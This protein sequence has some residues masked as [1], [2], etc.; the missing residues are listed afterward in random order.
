[1]PSTAELVQGLYEI[2]AELEALYPGRPFT[3]DGHLV[4]SIGET[5]VAERY[6]LKLM[7][8]ST[9][10]YDAI[11][12]IGRKVEIKCTQGKSVAFRH[13]PEW[14]I[15]V[16]LLRTGDIEE[17]YHGPGGPVWA[18]VSHKPLPSNGQYQVSLSK[19]VALAASD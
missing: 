2:V 17:V 15:V 9:K 13:E 7:P 16:K 10:G 8:P 11:D 5:L 1:M 18:L 3:P 12:Q 6:G 14:C 19:L 4:G